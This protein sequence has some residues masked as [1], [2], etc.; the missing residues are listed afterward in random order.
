MFYVDARAREQATSDL[1]FYPLRVGKAA[2]LWVV[3]ALAVVVSVLAAAV[4]FWSGARLAG[5][6]VVLARVR[7]QPL[8]GTLESARAFAPDGTEIPLRVDGNKLTPAGRLLPGE[9]VTVEVVVRRP[10]WLGWALGRSR[11]V[12]L[13]L[14]AP[15]ATVT[16]RWLVVPK[17]SPVRVGFDQPVSVVQ[18]G[19]HQQSGGDASTVSLGRRPAVGSIVLRVA[20]RSWEWLGAPQRVTWFGSARI[21]VYPTGSSGRVV[22]IAA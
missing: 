12:R 4:L 1:R 15:V 21:S 13:S 16:N 2:L 7:V 18:V 20:A 14:R 22:T 6:P 3:G 17:G 9:R 19:T 10:S 8:G 5:D 11:R